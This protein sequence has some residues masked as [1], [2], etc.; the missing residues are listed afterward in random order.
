MVFFFKQKNQAV[1]RKVFA[2]SYKYGNFTGMKK[3][4]LVFCV[5][6]SVLFLKINSQTDKFYELL[7]KE[8]LQQTKQKVQ[9]K[10]DYVVLKYPNGDVPA[11]TGVC[12]DLVIR[13]YRGLG[14]D[15]QKEVHEDMLNH[16]DKY[17]KFWKLKSSDSN[18]DHRRVPNLMVYFTRQN[19]S[20]AVTTNEGDYQ[21][22]DLV[23][24]NLNNSK[25]MSGITHIGIVTNIPSY[26]GKHFL[27]AHNIGGGNVLEDM[28][29]DYVIIGHYRF[30][31]KLPTPAKTQ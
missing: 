11:N 4:I 16:F 24:W 12:T 2:T 21:P 17:P 30:G 7:A 3:K 23:T 28:L 13:A 6:F 9:Y 5:F 14:I 15:L 29:F 25:T 26:T 10:A 31:G 20:I 22:G 18:I 27:V 19:A 8:A 1:A